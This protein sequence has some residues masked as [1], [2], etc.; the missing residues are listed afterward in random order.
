MVKLELTESE[1]EYL[2]D[3]LNLIIYMPSNA[4]IEQVN[5]AETLKAKLPKPFCYKATNGYFGKPKSS[6]M[7]GD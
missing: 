2:V 5:F 4:D 7:R 6:L 1:T 3:I